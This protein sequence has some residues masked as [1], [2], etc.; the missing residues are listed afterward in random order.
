MKDAITATSMTTTLHRADERLLAEQLALCDA[1]KPL[2]HATK[3]TDNHG[4]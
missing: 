2:V 3:Q 1:L 4:H